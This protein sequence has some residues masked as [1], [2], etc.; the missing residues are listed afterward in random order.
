MWDDCNA[1]WSG[2]NPND[3]GM[4]CEVIGNVQEHPELLEGK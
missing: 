4:C 3:D 2:W 1:A